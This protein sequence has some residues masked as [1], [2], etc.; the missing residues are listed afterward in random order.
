MQN[1]VCRESFTWTTPCFVTQV[2]HHA[3]AS[4]GIALIHSKPYQPEGRGKIER[5]FKSVRMQFLS[6]IPEGLSLLELNTHFKEWIDAYHRR[7]HG[8]TKDTPLAR[9]AGRIREAPKH[10]MDHFRKRV[11]RKVDK[12]RT[13]SLDGRLYEAPAALIGKTIT[14]LYH[15]SDPTRVELLYNE[16]SH[17]MAHPL[18]VHINAKI[19]RY[20]QAVDLI[21]E[22]DED[23][24]RYH[25]GRV[26]ERE[27]P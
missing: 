24:N 25:G 1:G 23:K 5:F 9:Y 21:T 14:L 7:G 16:T 15:E 4:L 22:R 11:N 27:E 6:T 26:F 17:G 8:S 18:D 13:I 19:K 12:H 10:L 2:L 20:H 3:C